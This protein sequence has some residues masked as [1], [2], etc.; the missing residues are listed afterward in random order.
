MMRRFLTNEDDDI[1]GC[2]RTAR[3]GEPDRGEARGTP[4]RLASDEESAKRNVHLIG[5]RPSPD[6]A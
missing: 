5:D 1:E 4:R 3:P 6:A 2:A